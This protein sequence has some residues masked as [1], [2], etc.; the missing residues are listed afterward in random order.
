MEQEQNDQSAALVD[1]YAMTEAAIAK[2]L[3]NIRTQLRLEKRRRR[4]HQPYPD[5]A[6]AA[7]RA[8]YLRY[9]EWFIQRHRVYQAT[10]PD[11]VT[12]DDFSHF[13][14]DDVMSDLLDDAV[15]I[16]LSFVQEWDSRFKT[17]Q[18]EAAQIIWDYS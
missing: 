18:A 9:A 2:E 4:R 3:A 7:M 5:E 11:D 17:L 6:T 1:Q 8:A 12:A 10:L 13:T 16:T 15:E 14:L